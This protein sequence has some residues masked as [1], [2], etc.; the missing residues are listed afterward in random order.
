MLETICYQIHRWVGNC[1][2]KI[3]T[4]FQSYQTK[5]W[6]TK[7]YTTLDWMRWNNVSVVVFSSIVRMIDTVRGN[8]TF[9]SSIDKQ[10]DEIFSEY[11]ITNT[12]KFLPDRSN[13]QVFCNQIISI[14]ICLLF[15]LFLS[16]FIGIRPLS[17]H[18]RGS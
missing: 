17:K 9:N 4:R 10:V 6:L 2:V 13:K 16:I 5:I 1:V 3:A 12:P 18:P 14:F 11:L 7:S 8:L 15:E